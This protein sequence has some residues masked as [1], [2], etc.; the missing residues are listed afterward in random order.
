MLSRSNIKNKSNYARE[1]AKLSYTRELNDM[2]HHY[3]EELD[4]H[5]HG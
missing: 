1:H 5:S 4:L 2:R 3:G